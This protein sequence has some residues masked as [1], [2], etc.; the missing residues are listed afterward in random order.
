MNQSGS[1]GS[2]SSG[3]RPIT[4]NEGAS[5]YNSDSHVDLTDDRGRKHILDGDENGGGGHRAGTGRSGKS[6]FPASWSD[7]EILHAISDVATD[8][9]SAFRPVRGGRTAAT[10]TRNGIDIEVILENPARRGGVRIVTGYPTN[11]PRNR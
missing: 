5:C 8:P 7:D 3:G 9:S 4:F 2:S 1:F 11:V 6:E 10:G